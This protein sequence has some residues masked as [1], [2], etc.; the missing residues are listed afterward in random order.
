M[1]KVTFYFE[2]ELLIGF[3]ITGHSSK[4]AFDDEGRIVCSA[5]SS[6]AYMA[7]NT[8]T[9]IVGAKADIRVSEAE[10]VLKV[11]N[12]F[13]GCLPILSGLMLHLENLSKQYSD[14]IVLTTEV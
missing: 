8:I 2:D 3:H 13:E 9:E 10:M 12:E 7:A 11:K 4:D 5:V 1:T 14:Y 6:A